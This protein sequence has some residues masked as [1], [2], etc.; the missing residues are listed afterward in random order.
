[1]ST[2]NLLTFNQYLYNNSILNKTLL[3]I[4]R[5]FWELLKREFFRA[6]CLANIV[7]ALQVQKFTFGDWPN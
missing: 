3:L 5:N 7:K 2:F 6:G 4:S 1:M